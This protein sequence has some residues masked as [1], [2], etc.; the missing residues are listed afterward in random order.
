MRQKRQNLLTIDVFVTIDSSDII[1]DASRV[2]S[3]CME[4]LNEPYLVS[5]IK[6]ITEL[7][8][9]LLETAASA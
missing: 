6:G 7:L 1:D 8:H 5:P 2:I 4:L 9:T 3:V